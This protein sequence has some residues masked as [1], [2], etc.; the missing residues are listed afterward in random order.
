[1][2]TP[3]G[4][5]G[6]KI[7][8][9]AAGGSGGGS[10]S[11]AASAAPAIASG[12]STG[13]VPR[14]GLRKSK[15]ALYRIDA[16]GRVEQ[17]FALA[18]GYLTSLA[19]AQDGSVYAASGAQGRVHR[20][21]PDGTSSLVVDVPERQV[22]TLSGTPGSVGGAVGVGTATALWL[23][24][25]DAAAVYA[26]RTADGPGMESGRY[27][28]KVLDADTLATWGALHW[29]GSH[30]GF[31]TRLGNT[32]K[33]DGS[34]RPWRPLLA[35]SE[36]RG[37]GRGADRGAGDRG[38]EPEG[39]VGH[40]EE[41]VARAGATGSAAPAHPPARYL[42]YRATLHGRD[43]RL[44]EVAVY[45][46]PQ[47]QRP[48]LTQ[49]SVADPAAGTGASSGLALG[50][51]SLSGATSTSGTTGAATRPTHTPVLKLRWKVD[52][53]DGDEL[54]YRLAVRTVDGAVWR[55]LAG[56]GGATG[57]PLTKPELDWNT[58][59]IPDGRYVVR[60][61]ASDER[62]QAAE[63]ALSSFL[64]SEPLLVDNR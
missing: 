38:G 9:P 32:A 50:L 20:V 19:V 59:A 29:R 24:A 1:V 58:E 54:V 6:T 23:G 51:G 40:V 14:P 63:R 46:M 36:P 28:S 5:K 55:P 60:V 52:N 37:E 13:L 43:A 56:M 12:G 35:V 42:Q 48:R 61:T 57:D 17:V 31:E 25:G 45:V 26:A 7:V 39:G 27:V 49:I 33:P 44:R 10:S 2:A 4:A 18:D 16:A 21:R 8:P 3:L 22:L 11:G 47:N 62:S 30:V 64:D 41:P 15:A 53:E 34:W